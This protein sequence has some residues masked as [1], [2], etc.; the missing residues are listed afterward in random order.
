[1][2]LLQEYTKGLKSAKVEEFFDLV[3]YR[4]LAFLLVRSISGTNITPNQ[5]TVVSMVL[6][7][8]GGASYTL[9][10]PGAFV[11]GGALYL[12]YNI[13]DCSD[14]Q[15]ARLKNCSTPL[16]RI[17]DGTADYVVSI[18]AYVGIGVGYAS[19]SDD[20]LFMWILTTVAG[21]SNAVQ[22][23]FLDY[24]RNR[25]LDIT[26]GRVSVLKDQQKS[27]E[28]EYSSLRLEKG[29]LFEKFLLWIYL[30]YS[31]LQQKLIGV[32]KGSVLHNVDPQLYVRGN[33]ILI[34]FWTYLGPTTQ[35]TA[36]IVCSFLN[37]LDIYL[38]AIAGVGNVL[39]VILYAFQHARDAQLKLKA[40]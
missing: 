6:G 31:S 14:G 40:A 26:L 10:T 22:S 19:N 34:H 20:P 17:L 8:L 21:F 18:A 3:F 11:A 35:W 38:W 16:G 25:Y 29:R 1:M 39:A 24:Y 23:G 28:A 30:Q 5:L 4:P 12:L 7:V 9:G 27:F 36:L 37:R 2:S 32:K 33:R 13:V 15:L